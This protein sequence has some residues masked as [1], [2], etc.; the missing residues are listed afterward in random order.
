VHSL[1]V[2]QADSEHLVALCVTL[3]KSLVSIQ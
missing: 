3:N 1:S 2:E